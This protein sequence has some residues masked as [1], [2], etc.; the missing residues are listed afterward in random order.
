MKNEIPVEM[1][2]KP[3]ESGIAVDPAIAEAQ[4]AANVHRDLKGKTARGALVSAVGQVAT[5]VLRMGSMVVLARLLTPKDFGLVGM[6]TAATG[7]LALFQDAGLSAA[8]I[9]SPSISRAQSSTLFWI[10]LSVGGLLA[11]LCAA[12]APALT[13]FYHEPRLFWVT[14]FVATGFLFNGA[15]TQHRAMLLREMKIPALTIIDVGS[16][17][18]TIGL[19]VGFAAAGLGY[20]ALVSMA[21][22][23]P[24]VSMLCVW[25]AG[26]WIPG[27][28]QRRSGVWSMIK[29]GS[30]VMGNNIVTYFAYNTDKIL[31]GKFCGA[32]TLGLYGRA[33]QLINLPTQNLNTTISLVA[34]P[35]L[36]RLQNDPVRLRS[37]FLKGYSLLIGLVTPLTVACAL[38]GEQIIRVFLGPKW[39]DAIPVFRLLSPTILAFALIN[40]FGWLLLATGR[41]VRSFNLSLLVGPVVI[42]GYAVGLRYGANGVAAGF[43][44]SLV[45]LILPIIYW[46]TRGLSITMTDALKATVAPFVSIVV[47]VP[48]VL[49]CW[50]PINAIGIPLVQLVAINTVLFGVYLLMLWFAMGQKKIYLDL[51]QGLGIWPFSKRDAK[52]II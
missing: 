3:D 29:Y 27:L 38:F 37:Y 23:G 28:P 33:Y 46:A 14:I 51:L 43:S 31:L 18:L 11:L 21:V 10:N 2:L 1:P 41:V 39:G 16:T 22:S 9:Q 19:G 47:A 13:V 32:Q 17:I 34:F 44:I 42:G 52:G 40:P 25:F 36:S 30:T 50:G 49:I 4:S 35:A 7:F 48:V 5:L 24:A 12:T 6:A 20:W 15:A 8:A 26:R 45:L